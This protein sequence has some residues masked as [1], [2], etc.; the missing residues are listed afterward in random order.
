MIL[1]GKLRYL[2]GYLGTYTQLVNKTVNLI[3]CK[4]YG[5]NIF[6]LTM[7]FGVAQLK[8]TCKQQGDQIRK[9]NKVS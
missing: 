1:R 9:Q 4:R 3:S 7:G 8:N 2:G 5:D 6:E